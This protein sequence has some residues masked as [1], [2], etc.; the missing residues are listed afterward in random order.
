MRA[1]ADSWLAA[2]P[3]L[4]NNW[5][6]T[7]FNFQTMTPVN[8]AWKEPDMA[9]GIAWLEYMAYA[10]FRDTKYLAGADLCMTQMN[11]RPTNPFYETL[12]FF[13]PPLAARMNAELGRSYSTSRHLNWIFSP[14]SD[15]R[16]GWGC[17]SARWGSYDAYGLA[18]STTDTSGY[19][20]SMNSF[21]AAGIIAPVARYEP[22]YARLL[23]R[24]LLH[25][26]ANANLFYPSTLP[27]NMQS[28]GAW[29]QQTGVQSVSYE[30]VRHLGPTTPYATGDAASPIQDLNPY[31]AWGSGWMAA[32]FQTSNVPGI[33]RIDC[34]ATEAFAPPAH[35]TYLFYN[36]YLSPM[37]VTLNV[38][39][40]TTHL[41]D[42]VAGG[43]LAT[44][45]TGN[46]NFTVPA[47]TA[48]VLV[49]CPAT[50]A[51]SQSGQRL[52]VNGI[53]IDYWNGSLDS[54]HDELPDWWETRFSGNATNMLPQ[55]RA[56][57]GF[58][59][60]ESFRLGLDPTNPLSTFRATVNFQTGSSHPQLTWSSVGGKTYSVEYANTLTS[61]GTIFTQA[62]TITETN[63][64]AGAESTETFIDDYSLTGGPPGT[65]SRFYR[66]RLVN[67]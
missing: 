54:D 36:P 46:A 52:L 67:P 4:S 49:E 43:F 14:G 33:L 37:Q 38:G 25:V 29:V 21:T 44:N 62:L 45:V 19:A 13:G 55:G 28:S 7:G 58:S 61:S 48:V 16:P 56:S 8:G 24:W 51:I 6:H 57:N 23:G 27:T 15:A 39:T 5:E 30:G 50:G 22:Q 47:D 17:E 10:Q 40:N 9:I 3:V 2:L 65:G 34:V 59:N 11:N 26:A 63:V 60:L 31:G 20:F 12:G 66:V 53:V 18:G 35:Q 64:A 1:I 42:A 32:L 41:Y